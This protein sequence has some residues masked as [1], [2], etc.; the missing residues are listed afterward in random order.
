MTNPVLKLALDRLEKCL[1]SELAED[2][3]V[4]L[5]EV[6][7]I[8]FFVDRDYRRNIDGFAGR[9]LFRSRDHAI[10]VSATFRNGD[11][12]LAEKEIA[13]PH[14]TVIFKDGKALMAFLLSGN[15][16]ILGSMLRQEVT[17][18]GN[19]NYL[20]KFAY[21]ARRLQLMATGGA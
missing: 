5:L 7:K 9:Y 3:L 6:M 19:L 18:E 2:F 11:L 12:H 15:P 21:M 17:P 4:I 16:D 13:D 10:G 20:Y 1:S 14:V 8:A